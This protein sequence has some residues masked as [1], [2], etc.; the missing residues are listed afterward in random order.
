MLEDEKNN[1]EEKKRREV[2]KSKKKQ[3]QPHLVY[4]F[5]GQTLPPSGHS[6]DLVYQSQDF[7][8][9]MSQPQ[10]FNNPI[11]QPD[12]N[13]LITI[14]GNEAP[15]LEVVKEEEL[16]MDNNFNIDQQNMVSFQKVHPQHPDCFQRSY[17]DLDTD[18]IYYQ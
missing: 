1:E 4:I 10:G 18:T 3:E 16:S 7:T 13:N 2:R 14:V 9:P 5:G 6:G 12:R 11:S 17:Y 8:Y 15:N